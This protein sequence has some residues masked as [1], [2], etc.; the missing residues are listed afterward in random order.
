MIPESRVCTICSN[1]YIEA[2]CPTCWVKCLHCA[3]LFVRTREWNKF[4]TNRC[5]K[6][7]R[8]LHYFPHY[9]SKNRKRRQYIT[10]RNRKRQK[11]L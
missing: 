4:C 7:Y 3:K 5:L 10:D 8:K 11:D 2:L 9:N 1:T 6:K